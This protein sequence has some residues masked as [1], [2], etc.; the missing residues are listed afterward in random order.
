MKP[1]PLMR[2][3]EGKKM[4]QLSAKELLK[5]YIEAIKVSNDKRKGYGALDRLRYPGEPKKA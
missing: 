3:F 5:A 4:K 2:L 1:P